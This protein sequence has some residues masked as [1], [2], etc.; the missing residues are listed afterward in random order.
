SSRVRI[1]F[2]NHAAVIIHAGDVHLLSDPWLEGTVFNNSWSHLT[3]TRFRFED[4][5]NI[6]HLWFSHEHPDHFS[7]PNLRKIPAP[8]RARITV[9]YK[10]TRDR[11]VVN[12][13]REL[14]FKQM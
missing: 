10:T 7:P 12:F 3:E 6:T 13:C 1:E 4:F 8:D 9:L 2:V 14:G 5:K 11:K